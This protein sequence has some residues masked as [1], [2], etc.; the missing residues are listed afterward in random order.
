[1]DIKDLPK[2]DELTASDLV[3]SFRSDINRRLTY[4]KL[5]MKSY[6]VSPDYELKIYNLNIDDLYNSYEVDGYD[7]VGNIVSNNISNRSNEDKER[8]SEYL[9][10][11]LALESLKRNRCKDALS[12]YKKASLCSAQLSPIE[13]RERADKR[14]FTDVASEVW[15]YDT[16]HIL[17]PA[18]VI[19]ISK[20]I[21][22]I[23]RSEKTLKRWLNDEIVTPIEI[24]EIIAENKIPR[25]KAINKQRALLI[26]LI[27][28]KLKGYCNEA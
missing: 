24:L 21:S 3:L 27:C 6:L 19:K 10:L 8:Y 26:E 20:Q 11:L 22:G 28:D 15:S 4:I 14:T 5:A 16:S 17:L 23:D 12:F 1:M 13:R 18:H 2:I 7:C 9:L 25:G